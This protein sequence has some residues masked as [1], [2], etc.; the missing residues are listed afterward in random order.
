MRV[1][2][3]IEML[4][5]DMQIIWLISEGRF[6]DD[7]VFR[8]AVTLSLSFH[9]AKVVCAARHGGQPDIRETKLPDFKM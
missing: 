9:V 4:K 1:L 3:S 8:V 5:F 6:Y 2:T 7:Y